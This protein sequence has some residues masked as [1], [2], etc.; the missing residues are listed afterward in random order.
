MKTKEATEKKERPIIFTADSIKKIL[1]GE[2][3]MTRRIV[4]AGSNQKWLTAETINKV[5]R[6]APSLDNWWTIAVGKETRI[7]HCG[8]EM[9]GGHIGSI[10]CPYGKVGDLLWVKETFDVAEM[11]CCFSGSDNVPLGTPMTI[12]A[13]KANEGVTPFKKWKSPRFMPR[14]YSRILLEI[15]NIRVERLQDISEW[16]AESEGVQSIHVQHDIWKYQVG[17]VVSSNSAKDAFHQLWNKINGAES[18]QNNPFVW[19]IEF[20]KV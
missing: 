15:T 5:E 11:E 20:T 13:Y 6:F 3:T 18:W 7:I 16:D 14:R 2:K 17:D 10:K 1:S 12:R 19:V 9:D 8:R 4:K